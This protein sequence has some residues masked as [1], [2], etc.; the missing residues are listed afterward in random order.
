[1]LGGFV[2]PPSGT[3]EWQVQKGLHLTPKQIASGRYSQV[4]VMDY[5]ICA[6][7][8]LALPSVKGVEIQR[9]EV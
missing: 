9:D 7:I 6:L 1:M 3:G 5:C 8:R 4:M 2:I